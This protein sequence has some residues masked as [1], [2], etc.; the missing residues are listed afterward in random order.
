MTLTCEHCGAFGEHVRMYRVTFEDERY[1]HVY[2]LQRPL[3]RFHAQ[4][5]LQQPLWGV[6]E[7]MEPDTH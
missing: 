4:A 3:C 6:L 7:P 1:G 2:E 5:Y